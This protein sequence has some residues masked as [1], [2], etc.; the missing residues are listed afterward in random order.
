MN[1]KEK[2]QSYKDRVTQL[3]D[4]MKDATEEATK[5]A[6][7][8]P[9]L[10]VLGYD[11][12]N[13]HEV[14]PE[15]T[16]DVGTKKGEKVDYAILKDG[17]PIILVEAKRLNVKLQKAQHNQLYRY[18]STTH[19][20]IAI[21]TNG[22]EYKIYSDLNSPNIM[23][24]EPFLSF[25]I[26]VDDIE[27]YIHSLEN[28]VKE[29]FNIKTITENAIYLKY[30]KVVE[31]T[32]L[33]DLQSPSD[34]LVKYFLSRPD[35]K[36]TGKITQKMIDNHREVT[37]ETLQRLMGAIV[38]TT[39]TTSTSVV[40][41]Q[42]TLIPLNRFEENYPLI[43]DTLK[44]NFSDTTIEYSEKNNALCLLI[45]NSSGLKL[46]RVR[47]YQRE[48]NKF[49]VAIYRQDGTTARMLFFNNQDELDGILKSFSNEICV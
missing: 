28:L 48:N 31:K 46:S 11:V 15:F 14:I 1:F 4:T 49:D 20:R 47:A 45:Y 35:I 18:F 29:N 21:L 24:D 32:F 33:A 43:V 25:N 8:M 16:A 6:F 39:T 34:E 40:T 7:I 37:K 9:F 44:S 36:P 19:S 26:I 13:P 5:N 17:E 30:A 42:T 12:F 2:F 22:V 38:Q 10:S 23:D 3:A 41:Q 27:L